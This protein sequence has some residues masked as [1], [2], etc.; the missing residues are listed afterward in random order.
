[1]KVLY[2]DELECLAVMEVSKAAYQ[3][4]EEVLELCGPESDIAVKASKTE[5]EKI[6]RELYAN[7][8]ADVTAFPFCEI[9]FDDDDFEYED[10]DEFDEM[11]TRILEEDRPGTRK[12]PFR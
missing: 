6:I 1:M 12:L 9:E 4:E 2:R 11:L 7:G 3:D 5:S 8:K 10:E